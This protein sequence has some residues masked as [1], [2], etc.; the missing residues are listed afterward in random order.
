MAARLKDILDSL[1]SAIE[2]IGI[3]ADARKTVSF[4]QLAGRWDLAR[5]QGNLYD[6][7]FCFELRRSPGMPHNF[8][9][10][11]QGTISVTVALRVGHTQYPEL[12]DNEK[13][14][15]HDVEKLTALFARE[16]TVSGCGAEN[17]ESGGIT[18]DQ[19]NPEF[20]ELVAPLTIE[21]VLD[22]TI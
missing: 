14:L 3:D 21:Y 8:G 6:R 15:A 17:I 7:A 9:Y 22:L 10:G 20:F 19:R 5:T 12:L 2:S 16:A 11:D 13:K 4:K 18:V 1:K